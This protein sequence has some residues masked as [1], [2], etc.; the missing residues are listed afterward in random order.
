M[1]KEEEKE[2]LI[3]NPE[4][5]EKLR[6]RRRGSWLIFIIIIL[7]IIGTVWWLKA[8]WPFGGGALVDDNYKA[9]FLTN[10]QVYFGQVSGIDKPYVTLKDI[11]YLQVGQPLQPSEPASN[12]NLIKL[13][14]ELHGPQDLMTINRD[15][16]LFIEDLQSDSQVVQAIT[17]YKEQQTEGQ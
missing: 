10:D 8:G 17:R 5:P 2:P 16:I 7:V 6:P 15:H 4:K 3:I 11:F 13:G 14:G 1:E 12:V 9:V